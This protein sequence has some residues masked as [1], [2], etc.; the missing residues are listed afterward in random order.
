M[1]IEPRPI[2]APVD[3]IYHHEDW[4]P[5]SVGHFIGD[6]WAKLKV[7]DGS[8]P[9]IPDGDVIGGEIEAY[10]N[11]G[12][13]LAECPFGCNHVLIVGKPPG[14][15]DETLYMCLSP[16]LQCPAPK[17]WYIVR[18]PRLKEAIERVLL[19]RPAKRPFY[20]ANRNWALGQTLP[21]L[22]KENLVRG[23]PA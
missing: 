14:G 1:P 19:K 23:L 15:G 18:Y 20:A 4:Q 17:A 22:K 7:R 5:V 6:Q 21:A 12:R 2:Q 16:P 9:D 13:W 8:M 11:H 3:L 10:I